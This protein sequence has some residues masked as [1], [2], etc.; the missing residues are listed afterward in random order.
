M[1]QLL[2]TRHERVNLKSHLEFNLMTL[3]GHK[4]VRTL[5]RYTIAS[6]QDAAETEF[7]RINRK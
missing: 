5:G 3:T 4:D 6:Q 7:R 2:Y 1:S